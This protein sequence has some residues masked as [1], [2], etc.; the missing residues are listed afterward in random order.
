M[1]AYEFYWLDESGDQ[2]LIGLLPE[3][4][5]DLERVTEESILKWG[6]EIVGDNP[7]VKN[8]RFVKVN[9]Y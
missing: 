3:R 6:W 9:W 5:K 7:D 1:L 2:H 8:I 4:R